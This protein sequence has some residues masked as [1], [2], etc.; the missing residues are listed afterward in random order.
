MRKQI[1]AHEERDVKTANENDPSEPM[2]AY[3]LDRSKYAYIFRDPGHW[4]QG[5]AEGLDW[6]P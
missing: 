2:P 5:G 4:V 1:K 3:L 6:M